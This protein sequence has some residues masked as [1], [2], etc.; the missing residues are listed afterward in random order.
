[1]ATL[2]LSITTPRMVFLRGNGFLRRDTVLFY[3][4]DRKSE[5]LLRHE[6]ECGVV[7]RSERKV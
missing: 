6:K 4:G 3:E 1:M 5:A 2:H 7:K